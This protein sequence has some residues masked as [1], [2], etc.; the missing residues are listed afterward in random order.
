MR[1]KINLA[2]V[3]YFALETIRFPAVSI[4]NSNSPAFRIKC[5]DVSETQAGRAESVP[6][7]NDSE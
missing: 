1:E 5:G 6:G 3:A 2:W 4:M 7:S